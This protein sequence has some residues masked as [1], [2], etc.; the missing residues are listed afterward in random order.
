MSFLLTLSGNSF[1]SDSHGN[2]GF[3]IYR[4]SILKIGKDVNFLQM[5]NIEGIIHKL[6][7]VTTN[8]KNFVII[9]Y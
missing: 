6:H 5:G 9:L 8:I 1:D 7:S 3:K 4:H 2:K